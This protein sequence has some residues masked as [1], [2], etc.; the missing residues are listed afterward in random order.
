MTI[1]I[2]SDPLMLTSDVVV[3]SML[4]PQVILSSQIEGL[5]YIEVNAAVE[6]RGVTVISG[7]SQGNTGAAFENHGNLT[8]HNTTIIRNPLFASGEYLIRNHP[9][10]E[11]TFSGECIMERD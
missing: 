9:G 3:E 2:I 8:L 11:L 4:S 10:A 1:E 5:F 6:L 7:L